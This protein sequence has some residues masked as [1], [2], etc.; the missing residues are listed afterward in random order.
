MLQL[1]EAAKLEVQVLVTMEKSP[2]LAPP[3]LMLLKLMAVDPWFVKVTGFN[4]P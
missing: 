4:A 3:T 1:A 2:A